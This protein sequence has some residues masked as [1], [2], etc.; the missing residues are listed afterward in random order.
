MRRD[1]E[2]FLE[3]QL[4]NGNVTIRDC[5]RGLLLSEGFQQGYY[6]FNSNYRMVDQVVNC[7]LGRPVH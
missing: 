3:S 7:V 4:R 6:Q 1:R 2:P 5:M